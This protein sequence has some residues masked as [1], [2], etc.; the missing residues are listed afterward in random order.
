MVFYCWLWKLKEKKTSN[1]YHSGFNYTFF[2][3]GKLENQLVKKTGPDYHFKL[4]KHLCIQVGR[5]AQYFR[6]D[7]W[8]DGF[9]HNYQLAAQTTLT[10]HPL[11]HLLLKVHICIMTHRYCILVTQAGTRKTILKQVRCCS[12]NESLLTLYKSDTCSCNTTSWVSPSSS[13]IETNLHLG[14]NV[15][16]NSW[17]ALFSQAEFILRIILLR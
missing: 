16:K 11:L 7:N 5:S 15:N 1:C 14:V 8:F 3:L 12:K 9:P 4:R 13:S 17:R 2:F 10:L 6:P